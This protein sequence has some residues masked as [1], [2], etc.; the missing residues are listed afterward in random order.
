[1][2]A[3]W[4]LT[5]VMAAAASATA[6]PL[7]DNVHASDAASVTKIREHTVSGFSSG[8][9]LAVN[10]GVAFSESVLGIGVLGGSVYGCNVLPN[11]ASG[12]YTTCSYWTANKT[13]SEQWLGLANA[14]LQARAAAREIDPPTH[15][16]GRPVYLF[17]GTRD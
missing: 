4:Q 17:S 10:H 14:H 3:G 13:L 12:D 8:A 11:G 1:M 2:A 15:L 9:S 6:S 5:A 16:A 7:H